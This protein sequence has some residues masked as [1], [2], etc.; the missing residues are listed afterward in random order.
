[1]IATTA[2]KTVPAQERPMMS[3]RVWTGLSSVGGTVTK[4]FQK[5]IRSIDGSYCI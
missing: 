1:M 3:G 4:S 5:H 2:I